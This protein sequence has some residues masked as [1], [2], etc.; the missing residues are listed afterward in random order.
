[1]APKTKYQFSILLPVIG[2]ISGLLLI[3]L[4]SVHLVTSQKMPFS[5][6]SIFQVQFQNPIFIYLYFAL[7]IMVCF[8]YILGTRHDDLSRI[9]NHFEKQA[10]V[11]TNELLAAN[12]ELRVEIDKY[13]QT[14]QLISRAK[15][16]WEATFDAV[17][18]M[19]ILTNQ[20]GQIVRCNR[21]TIQRLDTSY[22]ALLGTR[23]EDSFK[24]IPNEQELGE[25]SEGVDVRFE[26][27]KGSFEVSTYPVQL[28]DNRAGIIYSIRD[29]TL[30]KQAQIE[31][32]RQKQFFEALFRNSP[33]AI[34]V[35]DQTQKIVSCNPAF[36]S[37]FGY[38][39][40][41]VFGSDLDDLVST[42]EWKEQAVGFTRQVAEGG[43]VHDFAQRRRKDGSL[44]DVEIAGVPVVISGERLGALAM[45][46][47]VTELVQA[48]MAAEAA[49]RAKSE[50]LANMSHEIRT[51]MNG[52]IG[53]LELALD[54]SLNS[55][56]RDY[57]NTA[58]ESADA[59]L[60][61]LN[62]ILDYSK[63][64]AGHLDLEKIEFDL[65]S[66]VEGVAST[67]A[68]RAELKNLEMV[69]LITHD[70]PLRLKGDPNRLRQVLVNL[71]GNAIKFTQRG[72]VVIRVTSLPAKDERSLLKF[73]V[74]DT[75]IGIPK[76][77][78]TAIFNRFTQVDSSTTRKYGGTGLG[79]TISKQLVEMMGGSIS[80]ESEVNQ[81]TTFSFIIPF[82]RG[83]EPVL[84]PEPDEIDLKDLHVLVVDD[85]AT[86]RMVLSRML[87]I[88]KCR[89]TTIER[90]EEAVD[91][92][93]AAKNI[94]DPYQLILLDM[95]MPEM[96]GEATL[97]RI[98]ADPI[99]AMPPVIILTSMGQRGDAAR[100]EALGCSGY[101]VKPVKQMQLFDAIQ[102]VLGSRKTE[103][104]EKTGLVT[105]HT[106]S[107]Q[108]RSSM[109]ILLAEDNPINQKLAVTLLQKAGY[110]VDVVDNGRQATEA[111]KKRRYNLVFMDVQMPEMDGLEATRLIREIEGTRAHTPIIAMTA[112]AMKGDRELCMAAGMDGYLSKPLEPEDVFTTIERLALQYP[113]K[114]G[115][116]GLE[117]RAIKKDETVLEPESLPPIDLEKALPRFGGD[118]D[119][120]LEMLG[121]FLPQ[122]EERYHALV[123]AC[124]QLDAETVFR[125][126][127]NL[128]GLSANFNATFLYN[129]SYELE[130]QGRNGDL[131][132][133]A[134]L[135]GKI[136]SGIPPVQRFY[137]ELRQKLADENHT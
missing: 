54:T 118:M 17:S 53:M 87:E 42:P 99:A 63:I 26:G 134:E 81:G 115:P 34:V 28:E 6:Q 16:S 102:V 126:A 64:E 69:S 38:R 30:R 19:I 105:R 37:L 10:E 48:R 46:H 133:A 44:I 98:K 131:S 97:M 57:L 20:E 119:F 4:A 67:L 74:S 22:R 116:L 55:E 91:V 39:L 122:L 89:P 135:I 112:H 49:D 95:Q 12:R 47:D 76:D 5:I 106:I 100:L 45:Y 114:T 77:R 128:K 35:L 59:L 127:H 65:R 78:L 71:V 14:E 88:F 70:V 73:S 36:E 121:E 56:Q 111:I 32:R 103:T 80:V 110:P 85:N 93:R 82:E 3:L 27:L 68:P 52:V 25:E 23:I 31:M 108:K 43:T 107:E 137:H 33:V 75:G 62:D 9:A 21:A 109:R 72:E 61:L 86:N 1:M 2:A 40:Q 130:T 15:K 66:T 18:E 136:A 132:N 96:D 129:I 124:D 41:E 29:V 83:T 79:L 50:F 101:L 8:G 104:Q 123:A 117:E 51:P 13:H 24:M 58:R 84:Q 125:T 92:L 120:F 94:G 60:S 11:R 90:G 113:S 7:V